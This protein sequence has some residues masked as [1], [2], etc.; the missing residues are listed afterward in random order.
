MIADDVML[1]WWLALALLLVVT[2][3]VAGLLAW[4]QNRARAIERLVGAIWQAGQRVAANTVHVPKLYG[5]ADAVE[6][7][8]ASAGRT[9]ARAE[10]IEAHAEGCPGCPACIWRG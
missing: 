3:V 6:A 9:L 5:I 10:A 4:L 2:L 7:I 1:L 8:L